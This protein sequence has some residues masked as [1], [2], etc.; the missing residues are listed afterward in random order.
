MT[1][2]QFRRAT[3]ASTYRDGFRMAVAS[4][5][6]LLRPSL[7]PG[8]GLATRGCR[9]S[10]ESDAHAEFSDGLTEAGD[11]GKDYSGATG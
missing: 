5:E 4:G 9:D 8:A 7:A 2:I 1:P 3:E 10:A 6:T 11:P